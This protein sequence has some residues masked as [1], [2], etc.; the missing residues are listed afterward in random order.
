MTR[1]PRKYDTLIRKLF[2]DNFDESQRTSRFRRT[3]IQPTAAEVGIDPPQNQADLAYYYRHRAP[4]PVEIDSLLESGE[5]WLIVGVG[6]YYEFRVVQAVSI[7]PRVG[8]YRIKIPDATPE[9]IAQHALS[10]EQ[11]LLAKVRVNRLIDIFT[12]LTAYSLQNHLRSTVGGSQLEVDELYVAVAKTGA[13]Y[14]IPVE[15]KSKG[16]KLGRLQLTQD[17]A[18]CA[19][20]FPSLR[21]RPVAVQALPDDGIAMFE[22]FVEGD[23]ISVVDERHYQLVPAKEIHA[24]DLARMSREDG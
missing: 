24:E 6:E 14:V 1:R 18:F 2:F 21:C 17:A 9:I 5:E 23:E 15:A 20:R 8:Q 4:L 12:G 13:Q 22:L 19:E 10:D 16:E 3:D 7:E 11:A